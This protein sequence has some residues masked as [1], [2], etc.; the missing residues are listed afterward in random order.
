MAVNVLGLVFFIVVV[1]IPFLVVKVVLS[2]VKP[3]P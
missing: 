2:V 3:V 1:L